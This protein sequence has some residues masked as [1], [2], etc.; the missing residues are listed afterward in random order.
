[1]EFKQRFEPRFSLPPPRSGDKGKFPTGSATSKPDGP[2]P[3]P[4]NP[5]QTRGWGGGR[6]SVPDHP[7]APRKFQG[8]TKKAHLPSQPQHALSRAQSETKQKSHLCKRL[9]LDAPGRGGRGEITHLRGDL[10][11]ATQKEKSGLSPGPRPATPAKSKEGKV[12][13][14]RVAGGR[15]PGVCDYRKC[16]A[17]KNHHHTVAVLAPRARKGFRSRTPWPSSPA[18][19]RVLFGVKYLQRECVRSHTHIHTP[20]HTL[21]LPPPPPVLLL[22]SLSLVSGG[23]H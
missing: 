19:P 2:T 15:Q 6:G 9:V 4:C 8:K 18:L 22:L 17:F 3:P 11:T 13:G 21:S 5:R 20:T 10:G 12:Q 23:C 7:P 14:G 16:L 1:M